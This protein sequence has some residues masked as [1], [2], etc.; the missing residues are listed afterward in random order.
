MLTRN[1][2]FAERPEKVVVNRIGDAGYS[3]RVDFPV[4]IE[5]VAGPEGETQ[6]RAD[7]YAI[8][9]G[10]TYDIKERIQNRYDEWLALAKKRAEVEPET[11]IMD[12]VSAMNILTDFVMGG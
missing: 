2:Y 10:F 9:T 6:Y 7:V 8:E 1:V 3:C 5:E 11:T 4:N 12:L